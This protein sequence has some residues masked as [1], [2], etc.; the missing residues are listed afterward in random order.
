MSSQ[1]VALVT[2]AS[3]GIGRAT[4]LR[5]ANDGFDVAINDMPNALENLE[6]LAKEIRELGRKAEIVIADISVEDEVKGL[7][8]DVV[9]KLGSLDVVSHTP[10]VVL[11][12]LNPHSLD[13]GQ[14]W[15]M[16]SQVDSPK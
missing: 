15:N 11:Y 3:Q 16:H 9:Q 8:S 13:G 2:G 4:S 14:C 7:I 12:I 1:A 5:L 10:L 6:S